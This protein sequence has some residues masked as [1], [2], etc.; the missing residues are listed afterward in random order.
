MAP[1][2]T[3]SGL[4][5]TSGTA[6]GPGA[7]EAALERLQPAAVVDDHVGP[8]PGGGGERPR[9][10]VRRRHAVR[11]EPEIG[12]GPAGQRVPAVLPAH[13]PGPGRGR[14]AT[15]GADVER[16]ADRDH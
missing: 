6:P 16:G 10:R 7:G 14:A 8:D 1:M 4:S 3:P 13:R 11:V 12:P 15:A 2:L 9:P 5:W